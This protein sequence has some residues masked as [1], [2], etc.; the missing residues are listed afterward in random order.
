MYE[1][2]PIGE[3]DDRI[4]QRMLDLHLGGAA[5]ACWAVLPGMLERG[6][7]TIVMISSELAFG[8]GSEDVHYVAAKGRSS[9]SRARSGSSWRRGASGSTASRPDRRTRLCWP[10]TRRGA[11]RATSP[12]CRWD[13]W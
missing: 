12:R 4:W 3:I 9:D 8:G 11:N 10:R 1:M 7:G 13:G 2:A 5:N 6:A